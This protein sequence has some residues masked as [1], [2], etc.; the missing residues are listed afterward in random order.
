MLCWYT[1]SLALPPASSSASGGS[2]ATKL[3]RELWLLDKLVPKLVRIHRTRADGPDE[4]LPLLLNTFMNDAFG[5][6]ADYSEYS[7]WLRGQDMATAYEYYRLQLADTPMASAGPR[8]VLK[9]PAHLPNVAFL[10]RM[11][12]DAAVVQL[13]RDPQSVVPLTLNMRDK[14]LGALNRLKA[15]R[16]PELIAFSME[17]LHWMASKAMSLCRGRPRQVHGCAVC[18]P[19]ARSAR[20]RARHL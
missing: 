5:M 15:F 14:T 10:M 18:G 19:G 9:S 2:R 8:W 7:T 1:H 13:H 4:C 20:C 12:P 16:L 11:F 3:Q 17:S 6:A